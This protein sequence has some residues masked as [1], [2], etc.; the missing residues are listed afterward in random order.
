MHFKVKV[1]F[2]FSH[3]ENMN[4]GKMKEKNIQIHCNKL[5][6]QAGAELCQ[7]QTQLGLLVDA[8]LILAV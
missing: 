2:Y 4:K 5:R 3:K 8:E 6:K 1:H 7:A